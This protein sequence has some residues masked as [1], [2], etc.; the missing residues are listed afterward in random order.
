MSSG[1]HS[2]T[3]PPT[4]AASLAEL[5]ARA[6][7]DPGLLALLDGVGIETCNDLAALDQDA[8]AVR[9]GV[10]GVRLWQLARGLVPPPP[11]PPS[12]PEPPYAE[13]AWT[14]YELRDSER[15]LFVIHGL[16]GTV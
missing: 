14:D 6:G 7:V 3:S 10:D 8:V 16:V 11:D 15:L 4:A 5:A 9:C 13:V 1:S 2:T 12:P